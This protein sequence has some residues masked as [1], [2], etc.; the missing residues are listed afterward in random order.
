MCDL[1]RWLQERILTAQ[2]PCIPTRERIRKKQG[3]HGENRWETSFGKLKN[4]LCENKHL[5]YKCDRYEEMTATE[6]MRLVKKEN[7]C[8]NCLEG[9]HNAD[10]CGSKNKCFRPGCREHHHTSLHD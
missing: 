10:K 9:N 8:F 1:E 2:E 3:Q 6:T 5:F 7:L 4:I